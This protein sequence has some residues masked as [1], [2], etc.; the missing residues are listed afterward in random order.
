MA[1]QVGEI[2]SAWMY[3]LLIGG[4]VLLAATISMLVAGRARTPMVTTPGG[5]LLWH[6]GVFIL[7]NAYVWAQDFALGSGLDY[8]YLMTI[9]WAVGLSIHAF[10][11]FTGEL[12]TATADEIDLREL[13]EKELQRS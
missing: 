5:D 8:A 1:W 11:Y 7:I 9:P 10:R 3:G 6:T 2:D 12:D 13:E 4:A